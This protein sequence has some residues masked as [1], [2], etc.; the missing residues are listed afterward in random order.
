M[1]DS[2]VETNVTINLKER[3]QQIKLNVPIV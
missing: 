3:N 1:T 2:N